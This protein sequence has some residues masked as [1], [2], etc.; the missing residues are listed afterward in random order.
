M[1]KFHWPDELAP[2]IKYNLLVALDDGTLRVVRRVERN[3]GDLLVEVDTKNRL[4]DITHSLDEISC[5]TTCAY[6]PLAKMPVTKFG[7][8]K[9][10]KKKENAKKYLQIRKLQSLLDE[11]RASAEIERLMRLKAE[12]D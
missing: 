5:W 11:E 10:Q 6:V 7:E 8:A 1:G 12:K 3:E 9:L 4:T 2:P